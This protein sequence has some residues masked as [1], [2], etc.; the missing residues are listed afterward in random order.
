MESQMKGWFQQEVQLLAHEP[1][2]GCGSVRELRD[3]LLKHRPKSDHPRLGCPGY[4][5]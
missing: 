3:V 4:G 5:V 2:G 1:P